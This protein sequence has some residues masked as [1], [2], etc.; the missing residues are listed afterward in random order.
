[1]CSEP[2]NLNDRGQDE[3]MNCL[4]CLTVFHELA[5]T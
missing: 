2:I 4:S 5:D 1:M 3:S